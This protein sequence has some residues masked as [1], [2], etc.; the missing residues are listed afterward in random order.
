MPWEIFPQG[1][2]L[3]NKFKEVEASQ[4]F[5]SEEEFITGEMITEIEYP[6]NSVSLALASTEKLT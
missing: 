5:P 2:P 1:T 6:H 4:E 3:E